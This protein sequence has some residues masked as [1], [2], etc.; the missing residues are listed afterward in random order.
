MKEIEKL[1]NKLKDKSEEID[2]LKLTKGQLKQE[3]ENRD[4]I[5]QDAQKKI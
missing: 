2:E 3:V 4:T 5:N 1:K